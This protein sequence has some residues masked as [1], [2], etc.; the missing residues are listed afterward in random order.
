[1]NKKIFLRNF[2]KSLILVLLFS[3]GKSEKEKTDNYNELIVEIENSLA[4]EDYKNVIEKADEALKIFEEYSQPNAYKSIAY[5]HQ[6]DVKN[7]IKEANKIIEKD[8]EKSLGT[9]LLALIYYHK[10][11]EITK[12]LEYSLLYHNYFPNDLENNFLIGTIYFEQNKYKEAINYFS[13]CID[14]GFNIKESLNKRAKSFAET[15]NYEKAIE[16]YTELRKISNSSDFKSIDFTIAS[17]YQKKQDYLISNDL[18]F[19]ID[20]VLSNKFIA[21]NYNYLN[22]K[23]S[24]LIYYNKY[25]KEVPNDLNALKERYEL[26]KKLNFNEEQ[27][28]N[29][30][31][32]IKKVEREEYNLWLKIL[33][34]IVPFGLIFYILYRI[35]KYFFD[36]KYYDNYNLKTAFKYFL[37]IPIGGAFNYT[38]N[39]LVV[40]INM[41]AVSILLVYLINLIIF[42]DFSWILLKVVYSDLYVQI[43]VSFLMIVLILDIFTIGFRIKHMNVSIRKSLSINNIEDRRVTNNQALINLGEAYD[44][45]NNIFR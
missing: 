27:L 39:I 3:C 29:Q 10:K 36:K 30:Y 22:K 23:D 2:F 7:A 16:D 28:F 25:I 26:L 14:N 21:Q 4:N 5:Y 15:D 8:G 6:N 1:M 44:K 24:A 43:I 32:I 40:Y 20:S 42:N 33:Y 18:F 9:K 31:K 45:L 17:Y 34:I 41:I 13:V 37:F 11:N 12:A 38:K 19:K 35:N